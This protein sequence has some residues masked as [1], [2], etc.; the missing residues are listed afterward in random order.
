M[1]SPNRTSAGAR[2]PRRENQLSPPPCC[3]RPPFP[4]PLPDPPPVPDFPL[5]FPSWRCISSEANV[6]PTAENATPASMYFWTMSTSRCKCFLMPST[7]S[8]S[9]CSFRRKDGESSSYSRTTVLWKKRSGFWKSKSG[10]LPGPFSRA[11]YL[12]R[13][14][15]VLTS[16]CGAEEEDAGAPSAWILP[17]GPL[18]AVEGVWPGCDPVG[19]DT[20]RQRD[21]CAADSKG[22]VVELIAWYSPMLT[23]LVTR[24]SGLRR[25]AA[26]EAVDA[27]TAQVPSGSC[28]GHGC[29][30]E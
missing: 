25:G 1:V 10:L 24:W 29:D 5:A 17:V 16:C 19:L 21:L 6:R 15:A 14:E 23:L 8:S 28:R 27:S 18:L 11:V 12:R 2:S 4:P 30:G 26:W 20:T 22:S 3:E 13:I 7:F 9:A